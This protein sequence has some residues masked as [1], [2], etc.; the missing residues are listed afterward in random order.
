[1][2]AWTPSGPFPPSSAAPNSG[3]GSPARHPIDAYS[4]LNLNAMSTFT[5]VGVDP[6]DWGAYIALPPANPQT[7]AT[8]NNISILPPP[9]PPSLAQVAHASPLV[10]PPPPSADQT[11]ASMMKPKAATLS[12]HPVRPPMPV[13]AATSNASLNGASGSRLEIP[14]PLSAKPLNESEGSKKTQQDGKQR[15]DGKLRR[16][17]STSSSG[18]AD[19]LRDQ[20]DGT[21]SPTVSERSFGSGSMKSPRIPSNTMTTERPAPKLSIPPVPHSRG[22]HPSPTATR[23]YPAP[24]YL[25]RE[26]AHGYSPYQQSNAATRSVRGAG[27]TPTSM[28]APPPVSRLGGVAKN[29]PPSLWMSPANQH[30]HPPAMAE[31]AISGGHFSPTK[32]RLDDGSSGSDTHYAPQDFAFPQV[33]SL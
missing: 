11:K 16:Q 13:R 6:I 8:T 19:Y 21:K 32:V 20:R 23:P 25:G 29:V 28:A 3:P 1:M 14:R 31:P 24:H 2:Y 12:M 5:S 17:L 9:P 15:P 4:D 33:C 26:H 22:V 18:I 30:Q 27:M 7:L 10:A